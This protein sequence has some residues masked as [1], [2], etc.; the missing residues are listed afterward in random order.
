MIDSF[1]LAV[2]VQT[3][4][5]EKQTTIIQQQQTSTNHSVDLD[6]CSVDCLYNTKRN[7]A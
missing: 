6:H 4:I 5:I 7:C 1:T 2:F 3:A